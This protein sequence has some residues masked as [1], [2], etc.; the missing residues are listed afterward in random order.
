MSSIPHER[1]AGSSRLYKAS[2]RK[3]NSVWRIRVVGST[4]NALLFQETTAVS[5]SA[6]A[7]RQARVCGT[8]CFEH[9][10]PL[11]RGEK[12]APRAFVFVLLPRTH[13]QRD[14]A[15]IGGIARVRA[16]REKE[17]WR[18]WDGRAG[19]PSVLR[20]FDHSSELIVTNQ[21]W[22][23]V[24]SLSVKFFAGCPQRI[25]LASPPGQCN[26][27]RAARALGGGRGSCPT[28]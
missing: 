4:F 22:F 28:S 1:I 24:S 9:F 20:C 15:G 14:F 16:D 5:A 26:A 27:C 7:R 10:S 6:S 19:H 2:S 8:F 17:G 18:G 21:P 23:L 25:G 13:G 3:L 12:N 11:P